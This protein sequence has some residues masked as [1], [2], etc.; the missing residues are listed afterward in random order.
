LAAQGF[1]LDVLIRIVNSDFAMPTP[2]RTLAV[3]KSL[4][5]TRSRVTPHTLAFQRP[6]FSWPH[7]R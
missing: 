1:E 7:G 2:E 4:A 5:T 6:H 3:G